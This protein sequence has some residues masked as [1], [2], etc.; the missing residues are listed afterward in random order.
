MLLLGVRE[1]NSWLLSTFNLAYAV[2][3]DNICK[4]VNTAYDYYDDTEILV[5]GK[6]ID[7]SFKDNVLKLTE[8]GNMTI[9]GMSKII[10]VPLMITFYDQLKTVNVAVART[11]EEFKEANY[12][13]FNTSL[14]EYMDSLELAMYR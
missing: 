5:D 10:K 12:Q 3:W 8:A 9:R 4:A 1:E 14:E 11:T 6:K 2:G 7:I 13:K